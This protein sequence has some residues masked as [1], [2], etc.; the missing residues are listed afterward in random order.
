MQISS[1][2]VKLDYQIYQEPKIYLTINF[3]ILKING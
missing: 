1:Y 3:V 2:Y